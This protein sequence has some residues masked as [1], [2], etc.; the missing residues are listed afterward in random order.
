MLLCSKITSLF[1]VIMLPLCPL[2]CDQPFGKFL[3]QYRYVEG[4]LSSWLASVPEHSSIVAVHGTTESTSTTSTRQL[5][6]LVDKLKSLCLQH[7]PLCPIMLV[8][9][10]QLLCSKLCQHNVPRPTQGNT[11]RQQNPT[12]VKTACILIIVSPMNNSYS[13]ESYNTT[14]QHAVICDSQITTT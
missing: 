6:S 4:S 13:T 3:S 10:V 2:P 8:I 5:P 7:L 14:E 11:S 12:V 9:E 1:M